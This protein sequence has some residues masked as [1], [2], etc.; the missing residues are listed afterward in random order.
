MNVFTDTRSGQ[1]ESLDWLRA[2]PLTEAERR[3][4]L[5]GNAERLL[6]LEEARGTEL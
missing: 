4:V 2:L 3:A 1:K 5:G 6:G